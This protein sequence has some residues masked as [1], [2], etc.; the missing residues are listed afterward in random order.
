MLPRS[1]RIHR[2]EDFRVVLRGGSRASSR[3]V[4]VH[5]HRSGAAVPARAGFVVGRSV[6]GSVLRNRVTRQLRQLIVVHLDRLPAG[7]DVVVRALPPAAVSSGSDLKRDLDS[8]LRRVLA[9]LGQAPM[10]RSDESQ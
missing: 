2:A 8:G 4:V 5:A 9:K 10:T 6:G 1:R 3:T 7:T